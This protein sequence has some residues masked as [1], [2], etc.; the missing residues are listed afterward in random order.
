MASAAK[1]RARNFLQ[2]LWVPSP[3]DRILLERNKR[4]MRGIVEGEHAGLYLTSCFPG[5]FLRST[6]MFFVPRRQDYGVMLWRMHADRAI[7]LS[8]DYDK[9]TAVRHFRKPGARFDSAIHMQGSVVEV[10]SCLLQARVSDAAF[11]DYINSLVLRPAG[12][13][14]SN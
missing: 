11:N 7:D 3:G 14:F 1:E 9:M 12:K 5:E 6:Q 2:L 13:Q 10:L 4:F 8:G